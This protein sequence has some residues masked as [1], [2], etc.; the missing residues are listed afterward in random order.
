MRWHT[1]LEDELLDLKESGG[2]QESPRPCRSS[3]KQ[4]KLLTRNPPPCQMSIECTDSTLGAVCVRIQTS[5]HRGLNICVPSICRVVCL[6]P[7][8]VF[9]VAIV[10]VNGSCNERG[11]IFVPL[12][13]GLSKP[14]SHP[15]VH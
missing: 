12:V 14:G 2:R 7:P 3:W 15:L 4:P 13:T 5:I 9:P 6:V 8:L 11:I 1:I 10:T